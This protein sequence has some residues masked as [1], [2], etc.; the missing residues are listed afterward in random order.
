M[1]WN[2]ADIPEEHTH[3][4]DAKVVVLPIGYE[5]TASYLKG[6]KNG[7]KAIIDASR[8]VE[9]YDEELDI[10]I[11]KIGIHTMPLISSEESPDR[12]AAVLS[13]KVSQ[14]CKQKKFILS[15]GGEHSV[16]IGIIKG[17]KDYYKNL[18]VLLL[19]AHA[20][21]RD[22]FED[23]KL[24]HACVSRRLHEMIPITIAGVRSLSSEEAQYIKNNKV[25]I[26]F[27][28]QMHQDK[29]WQD[30]VISTLS[31]DVYLSIDMDVFDPHVMPAV[32]TPEPG[33]LDWYTMI[34]FLRKLC[35]KRNIISCD[36]VELCPHPPSV[37]SEFT[38]AKLAYKLL[39]YVFCHNKSQKQ[40]RA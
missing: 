13:S 7:P 21:L 3:F 10:E 12:M 36:F 35:E 31:P 6:T 38:A 24:S 8:F 2:F 28:M 23:E 33:G 34:K 40:N 20:D 27:A 32:G 16:T 14:I 18:S 17:L 5:V 4:E 30:K 37:V 39:G 29:K 9:L 22:K 25:N 1:K 15:L 19:D 11:Y 26:Y